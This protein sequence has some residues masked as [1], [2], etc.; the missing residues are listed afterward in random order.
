MGKGGDEHTEPMLFSGDETT[1]V[2][3]QTGTPVTDDI[4]AE[5]NEFN[6]KINWVQ[7]DVRPGKPR[8]LHIPEEQVHLSDGK[9]VNSRE[10]LSI[11]LSLDQTLTSE[12]NL[13]QG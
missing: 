12:L 13:V 11:I 9:T 4:D 5:N 6:G 2:G 10:F 8:P 3:L 7:I 1:D